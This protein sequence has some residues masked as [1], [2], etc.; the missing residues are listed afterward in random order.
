[1]SDLESVFV[2][3]S[4]ARQI[5]GEYIFVKSEKAFR[6]PQKANELLQILKGQYTKDGQLL[7]VNL[8]TPHGEVQCHYCV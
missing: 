6:T 8:M 7:P 1:M 5:D 2:V 3:L 4:I